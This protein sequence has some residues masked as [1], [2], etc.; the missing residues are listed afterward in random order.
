[1]NRYVIVDKNG[2]FNKDNRWNDNSSENLPER[3]LPFVSFI[4][5]IKFNYNLIFENDENSLSK[6]SDKYYNIENSS[7]FSIEIQK[8]KFSTENFLLLKL[9]DFFEYRKNNHLIKVIGKISDVVVINIFHQ[10]ILQDKEML[11]NYFSGIMPNIDYAKFLKIKERF[12]FIICVHDFDDNFH[13][14]KKLTDFFVDLIKDEFVN[15]SDIDK[16][17]FEDVFEVSVILM[18]N[19]KY[20][21]EQ[22]TN[23]CKFLRSKIKQSVSQTGNKLDSNLNF[24]EVIELFFNPISEDN[25]NKSSIGIQEI[26]SNQNN[27]IIE[28]EK[29]FSIILKEAAL[30]MAELTKVVDENSKIPNF[31]IK[32]SQIVQESLSKFEKF[33][34]FSK[35]F[36]FINKKKSELEAI[37]DTSLNSIFLKQLNIIRE[38]TISHFKSATTNEDV[39]AD[40]AFFTADSFFVREAEDSVRPG[41]SWIYSNERASLHSILREISN[42]RKQ[43]I[44]ERIQ[45]AEHTA[46]A[47]QYLQMQQAQMQAIQQQ[48][49]GGS[50]GSWNIGCAYRPPDSNLNISMGYQQGRTNIQISM[51][52]DEQANLLGPNGFTSG[53]GPANLGV[54]LNLNL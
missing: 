53:V 51:I 24:S 41:S 54:S 14:S 4:N 18:E 9:Q 17:S 44:S 8:I 31:G 21:K 13:E 35:N 5:P 2:N 49:F 23:S 12:R 15:T 33:M 25:I 30:Q 40:F 46:N 29:C 52:P 48:Q 19:Y 42:R 43:L 38:M 47:F 10:N 34:S 22:F 45:H 28:G 36:S 3:S 50:P 20:N 1:M 7:D 39:P 6:F 16:F 32:S 27:C 11:K 37:I 26:D